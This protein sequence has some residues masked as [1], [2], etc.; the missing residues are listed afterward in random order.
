VYLRDIL[1]DFAEI[2]GKA[3]L[4]FFW[5]VIFEFFGVSKKR[6]TTDGNEEKSFFHSNL[7][8]IQV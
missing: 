5:M 7:Y 1:G 8:F 3:S 2:P 4:P 6:E